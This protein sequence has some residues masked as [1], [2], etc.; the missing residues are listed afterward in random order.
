MKSGFRASG[1]L[2]ISL[3]VNVHWGKVRSTSRTSLNAMNDQTSPSQSTSEQ[4]SRKAPSMARTYAVLLI[5]AIG[6][7]VALNWQ[8]V[9]SWFASGPEIVAGEWMLKAL[10]DNGAP[11]E[12]DNITIM[13][14]AERLELAASPAGWVITSHDHALANPKR[15]RDLLDTLATLKRPEIALLNNPAQ[16]ASYELHNESSTATFVLLK[17]GTRSAGYVCTEQHYRLDQEA[18][19]YPLETTLRALVAPVVIAEWLIEDLVLVPEV[20]V[21]DVSYYSG[22]S[23][24]FELFRL[25][26]PDG[27]FGWTVGD[28]GPDARQATI[29]TLLYYLPRVR[30]DGLLRA[31][32]AQPT[33]EAYVAQLRLGEEF[34]FWMER[35][36]EGD[37]FGKIAIR[38]QEKGPTYLINVIR[39]RFL[40]PTK[41][42]VTRVF[43]VPPAENIVTG[44]PKI[45]GNEG[46]PF[47][48]IFIGWE[49]SGWRPA[50]AMNRSHAQALARLEEARQALIAGS[51]FSQVARD[52]SDWRHPENAQEAMRLL[53]YWPVEE[54]GHPFEVLKAGMEIRGIEVKQVTDA[55]AGFFLVRRAK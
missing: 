48:V 13:K 29:D 50:N 2:P 10:S 53:K 25:P 28:G 46:V 42:D 40:S 21:K 52:Y 1:D 3:P 45:L 17:H 43:D 20:K 34:H 11:V 41:E 12:P 33:L 51:S 8:R 55:E 9:Q 15:V 7:A 6:I 31:S 35:P 23:G 24:Q 30:V 19:I 49:A 22:R 14:G 47:E 54:A 44:G 36:M 38:L 39:A 4:A 27:S 26:R 5:V 37:Q 16:L 32:D 18:L